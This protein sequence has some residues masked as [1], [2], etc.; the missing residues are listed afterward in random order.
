MRHGHRF[1]FAPLL[2]AL[3][4]NSPI[5]SAE[6]GDR[7]QLKVLLVTGGCCHDYDFQTKMLQSA[8][9]DRGMQIAWTVVNKGGTGTH[10]EIDL[11]D[12]P[13]WAQGFDAVVHN[14]CFAATDNPEYIRKITSAHKQGVASVVIHCAMHTYRAAKIDDWREFLGVTSRRHDHQSRYPVKVVAKDHPIMAN[15]PA[16]Y[17][18]PKD[19]LYIIEHVWPHTQVL[20]TSTSERTSKAHPVFWTNQFGK[21]RVFGTTYGHSNATFS[22]QTFLETVLRGLLWAADQLEANDATLDAK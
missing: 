11:Y 19:E 3:L 16:D 6:Q 14:E 20:A 15:F 8:A 10:A 1:L 12:N 21:A 4:L 22:D 5:W 7:K 18:T 17:V 13:D 2:C 9:E